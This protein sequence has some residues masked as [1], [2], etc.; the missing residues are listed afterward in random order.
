MTAGLS[1]SV[2][3][4]MKATTCSVFATM[5]RCVSTAP[6]D[7][8]VVPPVY[9]RKA[10]SSPETST[11]SSVSEA[12][13]ASTSLKRTAPGSAYAG[14]ILRTLRITKF[15]IA[16][17]GKPSMSPMPVT[18]TVR[19]LRARDHLLERRSPRSRR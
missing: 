6:L 12:P 4:G 18:T 3:S 16:A 15:V 9:C 17:F 8:P 11:G 5:F 1:N 7:T 2:S 13:F 19:Y 10:T 14:T